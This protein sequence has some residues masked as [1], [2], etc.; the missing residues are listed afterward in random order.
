MFKILAKIDSQYGKC[1]SVTVDKKYDEIVAYADGATL[2]IFNKSEL[3]SK[4]DSAE[5]MHI[6]TC[7][8]DII[9]ARIHSSGEKLGLSNMD[10]KLD[11]YEISNNFFSK[12][13]EVDAGACNLLFI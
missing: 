7:D 10:Y 5:P 13:Y 3:L 1:T 6:I 2:K 8:N 9:Q 11:V 12:T 4:L